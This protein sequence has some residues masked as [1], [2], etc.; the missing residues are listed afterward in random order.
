[1][2]CCNASDTL[3]NEDAG[4]LI[5]TSCGTLV[6]PSQV[7]LTDQLDLSSSQ[8]S[9]LIPSTFHRHLAGESR[10]ATWTRNT[11]S[12]HAF[13]HSLAVS[14]TAPGLAPR[15][16]TLFDQAMRTGHFRWGSKAKLV[17]GASLSIALRES[18]RPDSL[19]DIAILLQL[20][21]I[22]LCRALASVLDVLHISLPSSGPSGF[23][24]TLQMHL[25]S[26]LQSS[27]EPSDLPSAARAELKRIPV[28]VAAES[29]RSLS[30]QL[31][32][33]YSQGLSQ[34][35]PA[36]AACAVFI[37]ALEAEAR[38]SL[39]R[40]G[41]IAAFFASRCHIG[42][43]I[44][45]NHYKLLQDEVVKWIAEVEWLS[46]YTKMGNRATVS[47][48]VIVARGLKDAIV[49]KDEIWNKMLENARPTEPLEI[50]DDYDNGDD[51]IDCEME[52]SRTLEL[53]LPPAKKRRLNTRIR[54]ATQFLVEPL[55]APIPTST[56]PFSPNTHE[57]SSS[58][59]LD[60]LPLTSYL[61]SAPT[62]TASS[63]SLPTR[64]QLLSLAR[65]G[66]AGILDDELFADGE[67]QAFERSAQEREE[68]ERMWRSDGTWEYLE[69]RKKIDQT[70]HSEH[71]GVKFSR[72]RINKEALSMFMDEYPEKSDFLGLE[73]AFPDDEKEDEE[74]SEFGFPSALSGMRLHDEEA[75]IDEWRPLSP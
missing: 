10:Q 45:M 67:L 28:Q 51:F 15:A 41:D 13:I 14:L 22:K 32:R 50:K 63:Q 61:L 33:F 57:S 39:S 36:S 60:Y 70:S 48:R 26:A 34:M 8:P 12:I 31:P 69:G 5:C 46:S 43:G 38:T 35:S 75:V 58:S 2:K 17:A 49:W 7:V 29:A 18:K 1:M 25:V 3:W 62:F 40:L 23:L 19:R 16:C 64:L 24:S 37:L 47:K 55:T 42:K 4:S 71:G 56:I 52:T 68:M 6:D 53:A 27:T 72:S 59:K 65:G 44:V 11:L 74:K 21:H 20:D 30:E 73:Y 9:T 66:E 54:D